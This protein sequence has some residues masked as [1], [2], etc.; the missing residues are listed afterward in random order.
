MKISDA[1]H[2]GAKP[3]DDT[4]RERDRASFAPAIPPLR[5]RQKISGK[6]AGNAPLVGAL[7]RDA[8][9]STPAG[10]PTIA[11]WIAACA[12]TDAYTDDIPQVTTAIHSEPDYLV[13]STWS[14][15]P[16]K[17]RAASRR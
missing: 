11:L 6:R 15:T 1:V 9:E 12:A 13:E 16:T 2:E 4:N 3:A 14:S 5:Q 7:E 8:F 10:S 17:S